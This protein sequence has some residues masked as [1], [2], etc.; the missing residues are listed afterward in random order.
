MKTPTSHTQIISAMA[1]SAIAHVLCAEGGYVD[2]PLDRGGKTRFGISQKAYPDLDIARLTREQAEAI[3]YRDYWLSIRGDRLAHAVA[4]SVF[5]CAVNQGVGTA[6]KL[7]QRALSVDADGIIGSRTL[8]MA[9]VF[10]EAD[11]C[12]L[13]CDLRVKHYCETVK[14]DP[15]LSR[16][17]YGWVS[18]ALN[19]RNR[20]LNLIPP[21]E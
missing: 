12:R 10:N 20:S 6:A 21:L 19:V 3:Y 9:S 2:D 7:L 1:H 5:D 18:R 4:F 16:F 11:L 14:N 17:I 13:F 15:A 8:A